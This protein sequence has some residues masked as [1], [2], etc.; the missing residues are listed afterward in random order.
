MRLRHLTR[1]LAPTDGR[2]GRYLPDAIYGA[3]DG[4]ITTFAVVAGVVGA[5]FDTTVILV[6]GFANLL[7]DGFSM[8]A[9]NIL[10][11]RSQPTAEER[12]LATALR[13]G[14]MTWAS[15]VVAGSIPLIAYLVPI[16][17]DD[18]FGMAIALTLVTMFVIGASRS[19]VIR[20]T[21]WL[22]NGLEM[23]S[24]GAIAAAVAY[25]IGAFGAS[26]T[27]GSAT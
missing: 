10:A 20:Q 14:V 5:S 11:R 26:I 24:I 17:A 23:L 19:F 21:S 9:S 3:N 25:G 15:F 4:L 18:R 6:L 27:N 7:A 16:D 22:R 13:H 8:G 12:E 2:A 1:H